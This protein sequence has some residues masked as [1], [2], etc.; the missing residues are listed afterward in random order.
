MKPD[1]SNISIYAHG[2]RN[3]IGFDWHPATNEL[4]FTDNGRDWMGDNIPP[5]E[6]NHA[7]DS[8]MHFGF[9]FCH[10]GDITDNKFGSQQ[11]CNEFAPPAIKLGPHVAVLGMK[12]YTGKMFHSEYYGQIFIAEH[13]SWNRR[14][15]IGYRITLVRMEK[16]KAVSYETF[17]QGW[18]Q[19]ET[20]WGR[21]VDIL[22]MPDG[23]LLVSDDFAGAIYRIEYEAET[24][25]RHGLPVRFNNPE[26]GLSVNTRADG[27]SENLY[28]DL[29]GK[30][31]V[32]D[33]EF[34]PI[35]LIDPLLRK[36]ILIR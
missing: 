5:D 4:W 2:I 33:S 36:R 3:T 25:I 7:P 21:P 15:K 8:G 12:F 26:N 35:P 18:L 32:S 24:D 14:D 13:G 34:P 20:A 16:N 28:F 1:G 17:A 6:L 22:V 30:T 9:P 10:G 11:P 19:N 23:A 29:S 31:Y 27:F